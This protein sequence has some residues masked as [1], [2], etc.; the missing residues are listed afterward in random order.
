[1]LRVLQTPATVGGKGSVM[2]TTHAPVV[3][4]ELKAV[5]LRVVRSVDGVTSV[6]AVP[7]SLQPIVRKASEAFLA[8]KVLICE[9]KTELGFCRRLDQYW[10]EAGRSFGLAG[11][12]LANGNGTEAPTV[13][14]GFAQLGYDTILIG[15]SDAPLAP[16]EVVLRAAG[17]SVLLWEGG[18]SIEQRIALDLP[19]GGVLQMVEQAIEN[20]DERSVCDTV[21]AK[22]AAAGPNLEGPPDAWPWHAAEAALRK[23]IGAAAKSRGWFKRV[24]LAERLTGIVVAHLASIGDTDLGRKTEALRVWAHGNG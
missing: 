9:G 14:L 17:A 7:E 23:A 24:D 19:V 2:M 3:L 4:E 6:T 18:V 11:V 16:P 1:M 10:S 21:K 13:T 20:S 12:A 22:L 5:N 15:D 8:K